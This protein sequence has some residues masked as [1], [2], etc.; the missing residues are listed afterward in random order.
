MAKSVNLPLGRPKRELAAA[1]EQLLRRC[2][3]LDRREEASTMGPCG[4]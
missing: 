1:Q 4:A 2:H 3:D